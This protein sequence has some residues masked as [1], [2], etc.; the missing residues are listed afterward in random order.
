MKKSKMK[1]NAVVGLEHTKD[2]RDSGINEAKGSSIENK[3]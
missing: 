1:L 2:H 3:L